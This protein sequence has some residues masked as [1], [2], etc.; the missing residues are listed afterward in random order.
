MTP[1]ISRRGLVIASMVALAF[2]SGASAGVAGDRVLSARAGIRVTLDD[3]SALLDRLSLSPEQRSRAEEILAH[4]SPLVRAVMADA[5]TGCVD[6]RL[7]FPDG[8]VGIAHSRVVETVRGTCVFAFVLHAPPAPL[9]SIE[10]ALQA[11]RVQLRSEL[12]ALK[13]ALEQRS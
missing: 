7:G 13:R 5:A 12:Q 11:Q 8:A 6:W 1:D 3:G 4:R 2:V 10:G 9:E